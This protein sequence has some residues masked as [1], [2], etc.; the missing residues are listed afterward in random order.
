[1]STFAEIIDRVDL[2]KPN[3]FEPEEKLRWLTELDGKIAVEVLML[4]MD[5]VKKLP[6]GEKAMQCEPL[7][8]Y[9]Y[10]DL[11]DRWLEAKIDYHNDEIGKYQNAMEA[12]NA[13]YNGFVNWFLNSYDP[14]QGYERRD[15]FGIQ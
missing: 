12:Y 13:A 1:M 6:R 2:N 14:V 3:A 9:P 15:Y 8:S 10:E 5:L 4:N 7:V 11:Y